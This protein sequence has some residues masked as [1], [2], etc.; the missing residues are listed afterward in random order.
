MKTENFPEKVESVQID[1]PLKIYL[2]KNIK[3][4]T[5]DHFCERVHFNRKA[6]IGFHH[7]SIA[8]KI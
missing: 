1:E 5:L 2:L 3:Y 4:I 8:N 6:M 7:R